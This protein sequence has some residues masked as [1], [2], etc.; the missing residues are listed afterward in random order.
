MLWSSLLL[1]SIAALVLWETPQYSGTSKL[2]L[3]LEV[4]GLPLETRVKVW[5]G[6]RGQWP[7]VGWTGQDV[8]TEIKPVNE[9]VVLEA[10]SLP[11]AYRRWGKA[12]IPRRTAD[13]V[14]L[15][16]EDPYQASRYLA[17]PLGQDWRSGFLAPHRVMTLNMKFR[18]NALST[19]P[20]RFSSLE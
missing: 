10:L 7:G 15:R 8:A 11:V 9:K 20:S 12:I 1:I 17:V 6:P 14:V 4:K 5:A 16:F 2:T 19:D 18:W 13:L 3:R